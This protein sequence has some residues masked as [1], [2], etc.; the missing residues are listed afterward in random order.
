MVQQRFVEEAI[1]D[2]DGAA[3]ARETTMEALLQAEGKT[4]DEYRSELN[5]TGDR[6]LKLRF[7]VDAIAE[8][9]GINIEDG[10]IVEEAGRRF[11]K[12]KFT[13]DE[14]RDN[15]LRALGRH[16]FEEKVI[17]FLSGLARTS[18]VGLDADTESE[19]SESEESE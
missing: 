3:R 14:Q 4:Q 19:K 10:E 11:E 13:S 2:L 9:E 15:A 18:V 5:R 12:T 1:R 7:I 6:T 16:M 8:Q 17:Q